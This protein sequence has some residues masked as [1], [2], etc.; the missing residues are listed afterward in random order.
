MVS[1]VLGSSD[2][3]F[4]MAATRFAGCCYICTVC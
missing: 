1:E 2:L 4:P 3:F